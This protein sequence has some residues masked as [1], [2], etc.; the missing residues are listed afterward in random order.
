LIAIFCFLAGAGLIF[1]G[2]GVIG[3]FFLWWIAWGLIRD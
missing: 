1:T 3:T 2:I